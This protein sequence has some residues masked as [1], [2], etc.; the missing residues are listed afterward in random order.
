MKGK[1]PEFHPPVI[2]EK[3]V[4]AQSRLFRIES[5]HLRFSNGNE[6]LYERL[7]SSGRGAVM[8]VPLSAANEL[9][10][11]REYAAGTENY[12]LG[13]P[14][15][16]IDPGETA[17]Q[18]ANRELKEEIGFGAR[19]L[20]PLHTLTLAPGYMGSKMHVF[21]ARDLYPEQLLGDE[22]EP[23]Q[24]ERWP[25]AQWQALLQHDDFTEARCI[26][27]LFLMQQ[28]LTEEAT[29]HHA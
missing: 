25:L 22:P 19:G 10:M 16:I 20:V 26:A 29:E 12:E 2:L 27:A 8:I 3:N 18:A 9:M 15:G 6:R 5:L 28:F 24:L 4:V 14:K 1:A 23:L 7:Q 17:E 21:L 13:F 11:I